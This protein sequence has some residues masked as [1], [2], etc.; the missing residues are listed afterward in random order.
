MSTA[1]KTASYKTAY[2]K[3][4]ALSKEV[5]SMD[6]SDLDKLVKVTEKATG[7]AKIC[8]ERISII[9]E[10]LEGLDD[11]RVGGEV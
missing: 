10:K 2:M 1:S 5:E 11:G 7:Y 8:R 3:L 4:E 6:L 9:R